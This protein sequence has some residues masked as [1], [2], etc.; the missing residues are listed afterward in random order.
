MTAFSRGSTGMSSAAYG[1]DFIV[2][3][4]RAF[5]VEYARLQP[6]RDLQVAARFHRELR[7]RWASS[8]D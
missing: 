2:D 1:S 8:Y 4:M 7:R 5:D 3:L 6:R